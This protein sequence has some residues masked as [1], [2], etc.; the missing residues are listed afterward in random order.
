MPKK[1]RVEPGE[2]LS[3]IAFHHGLT[4]ET[5][6][7]RSE[8]AELRRQ[9]PNMYQLV[10]GDIVFIPDLRRRTETIATGRR[11]RFRALNVPEKLRLQLKDEDAQPRAGLPFTLT[12]DGKVHS[13]TTDDNGRIE[14]FIPPDAA[15]AVLVVK[16]PDG[17]EE[18]K[19]ELGHDTPEEHTPHLLEILRSTG[20]L[21]DED[22]IPTVIEALRAYQGARGLEMTGDADPATMVALQDETAGRT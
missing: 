16:A 12:V 9:R 21:G 13:G 7:E 2:C 6:W 15:A 19:L 18:Y 17:E 4:P 14:V 3:S 22:D 20:F 10:P 8:N 1:H 11:H 5:I